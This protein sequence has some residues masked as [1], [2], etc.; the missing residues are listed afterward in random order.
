LT[1]EVKHVAKNANLVN[2]TKVH[3][4]VHRV[5]NFH[6]ADHHFVASFD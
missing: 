1:L 6:F 2:M 3:C 5:R 4:L